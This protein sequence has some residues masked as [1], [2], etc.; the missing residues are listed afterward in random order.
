MDISVFTPYLINIIVTL[1]YA[2]MG[3]LS[4]GE[5]FNISKFAA[6]LSV[7]F[8]AMAGLALTSLF[9]GIDLSA[10]IALLPTLIAY[11]IMKLYSIWKKKQA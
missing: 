10:I 2:S 7:A 3:K 1:L 5:A 6:T 4:S 11:Y 8:A 9:S